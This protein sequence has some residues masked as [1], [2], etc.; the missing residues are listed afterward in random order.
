[1]TP[2]EYL[3]QCMYID[4][5]IKSLQSE[6]SDIK[7]TITLTSGGYES[8][9]VTRTRNNSTE[10]KMV[11]RID[12]MMVYWE[13]INQKIDEKVDLKMKISMEIDKVKNDTHRQILKMR[14]V[15][16]KNWEE[17]AASLNYEISWVYRL[18]GSALVEFE[19]VNPDIF[20]S[21][22]N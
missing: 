3:S 1:M 7:D 6:Y 5:E 15:S 20:K 2:K 10:E 12:K 18:H 22:S 21:T 17:I 16:L 9:L 4:K 19:E 11:A 13:E 8:D 14:Y